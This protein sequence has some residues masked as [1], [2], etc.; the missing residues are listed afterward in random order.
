MNFLKDCC[1]LKSAKKMKLSRDINSV[2]KPKKDKEINTISK[3]IELVIVKNKNYIGP[4]RLTCTHC[5]EK[6]LRPNIPVDYKI[7][8]YKCFRPLDLPAKYYKK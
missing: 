4:P 2:K 8:C 1:C 5:G 7:S 3:A 6:I